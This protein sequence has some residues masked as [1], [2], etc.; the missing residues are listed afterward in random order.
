MANGPS[1]SSSSGSLAS[2]KKTLLFSS[3][4][5]SSSLRILDWLAVASTTI[6]LALCAQHIH[7][8]MGI[9]KF[10]LLIEDP[11]VI[12]DTTSTT[13]IGSN[14]K[15][16]CD[17]SS[18]T[19]SNREILVMDQQQQ[20]NQQHDGL[21]SEQ[22]NDNHASHSKHHH[23]K[24]TRST[25][26]QHHQY[27][28]FYQ[29]QTDD[30]RSGN[31]NNFCSRIPSELSASTLWNQN[32]NTILHAII[33]T[34]M[35]DNDSIVENENNIN[36][37]KEFIKMKYLLTS[38]LL[39]F[40]TPNSYLQLGIRAPPSYQA[41]NLILQKIHNRINQP[42]QY[43]IIQ[44]VVFGSSEISVDDDACCDSPMIS[45]VEEEENELLLEERRQPQQ[46]LFEKKQ[47]NQKVSSCHWSFI[48]TRFINNILLSSFNQSPQQDQSSSKM[49]V[50]VTMMM[51]PP[52]GGDYIT[53]SQWATNIAQYHLWPSHLLSH[54][55]NDGPDIIVN[56]YASNDMF[57]P[58]R[59]YY[60]EQDINYYHF[61]RTITQNF[62]RSC[63]FSTTTT[64]TSSSCDKSTAT[65]TTST[66][67]ENND[68]TNA[69]RSSSSS[70][71]SPPLVIHLNDYIEE[72]NQYQ[73]NSI[74]A[75]T[76]KARSLQ[77]MID[78]YNTGLI[79][80]TDVIQRLVYATGS[81]DDTN[82]SDNE[83]SSSSLLL[84]HGL[85][86]QTAI[87]ITM[88]YAFWHYTIQFCSH[89]EEESKQQLK[90]QEQPPVVVVP[91]ETLQL[92]DTVIPP[93]LDLDL[94]LGNVTQLWKQEQQRQSE[95]KCSTKSLC[96]LT[97]GVPSTTTSTDTNL[98]QFIQ[99][100]NGWKIIRPLEGG[101]RLVAEQQGAL[102]RLQVPLQKQQQQQKDTL[103]GI[104][105]Q[106]FTVYQDE[107]PIRNTPSELKWKVRFIGTRG[108]RG[109]NDI[110]NN[111][112]SSLR[113]TRFRRRQLRSVPAN[114]WHDSGMIA[115]THNS[116]AVVAIPH[117]IE[118]QTKGY[119]SGGV[120]LQLELVDGDKFQIVAIMICDNDESL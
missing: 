40:L 57:L 108:G 91:S 58:L 103:D 47:S 78:Y 84:Q 100:N 116:P 60:A 90:Q 81:D 13:G 117:V 14:K 64:T 16:M 43:P 101:E 63:L 53:T 34:S 2:V 111:S 93:I 115:G 99:V 92:V 77:Q 86:R 45:T 15:V 37:N 52:G 106:L 69:I 46:N 102:L 96:Y 94:C 51:S 65:S 87:S 62:I 54:N 25:T 75:E 32:L 10:M 73:H 29:S 48:L 1:K 33:T 105:I 50:N 21:L 110:S 42:D 12:D 113:R 38:Q 59:N 6:V 70:K 4:S 22:Q 109:D 35:N 28:K 104:T 80:Y 89:Q 95:R 72:S 20:Q 119:A 31:N 23:E 97:F 24:S 68:N 85:T 83:S 41:W 26:Q 66:N 67:G 5:S 98:E 114:V 18:S 8:M 82:N 55:N 49:V 19:T 30:G 44:M 118:L 71:S 76:I 17:S 39:S 107:E 120:E 74:L 112:N 27:T 88:A 61:Q 56:S 9:S 3:T 36:K 79:S 11:F 7:E